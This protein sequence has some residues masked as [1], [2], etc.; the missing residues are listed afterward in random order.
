MKANR[1]TFIKG[2]NVDDLESTLEAAGP[3]LF[4]ASI[5]G[6]T[7]GGTTWTELIQPLDQGDFPQTRG[8]KVLKRQNFRRPVGLQCFAVPDDKRNNLERTMAAWRKA[9]AER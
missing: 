2:G 7:L 4:G 1:R 6:A 3:H 9:L 5:S 8:L